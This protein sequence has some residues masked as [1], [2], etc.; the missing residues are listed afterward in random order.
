M[1]ISRA[2]LISVLSSA[3]SME[4]L[5][6]NESRSIPIA[7]PDALPQPKQQFRLPQS[8]L[9]PGVSPNVRCNNRVTC[10]DGRG[11]TQSETALAISGD[12]VVCGYNDFRAA[13]CPNEEP[14]YQ[15][16]GWA[17]SLDGG[18]TFTDG[19]PLPGRTGH[20]GDPWLGTGP[21]GTIY[22]VDIWNNTNGLVA[23][24]G[25]RVT[26]TGFSWSEPTIIA[27]AGNFDKEAMAIDQV[28]GSIYLT[29]T[30]FGG[31]GGIWIHK[32]D[33]GGLT[34]DV[35]RSVG[36][37]G[38]GSYPA[39]GPN[40][41]LY[42]VSQSG[43][44]IAFTRSF[45][46]GQTF[47]PVRNIGGVIGFQ[48]PGLTRHLQVPQIAVDTSGGP[49]T[50]N[51]YVVWDTTVAGNGN[52]VI[53]TSIDG[54]DSWSPPMVVNDDAPGLH[55]YPT[56]SV[57]SLGRVNVFFYDRRENPGT[58]ITNLYFAQSTDGGATFSPNISVTDTPSLWANGTEGAP[59]YGDYIN[60]VSV[61][62]KACVAYA[63]GRDGD[64]D[65]YFTCVDM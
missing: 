37:G 20:R 46:G 33:D 41:E 65:A 11:V 56:V 35:G 59:N 38:T 12:A 49:N 43:P 42:V 2:A 27:T 32:S 30:R 29:Y 15:W 54:G 14:G 25:G 21:D 44:N 53:V 48:V 7:N 64:P 51:I 40:A 22:F 16:G 63:D 10:S 26:G 60:S 55:F 3:I 17:Y 5:A 31:P 6:N 50:G 1:T 57:D 9:T 39:I 45:D 24:R 61:G 62:T 18:A 23:V 36:L 13:F 19:G 8:K 34:F 52:A 28:S 58:N 47:S 4:G